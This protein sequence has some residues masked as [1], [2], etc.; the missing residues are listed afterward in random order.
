M[1]RLSFEALEAINRDL[2]ELRKR[3]AEKGRG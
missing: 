2:R 3:E 1:E